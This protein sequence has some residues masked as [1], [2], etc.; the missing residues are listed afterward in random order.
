MVRTATMSDRSDQL[1]GPMGDLKPVRE[2]DADEKGISVF[3]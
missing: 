1:S 2:T 3:V